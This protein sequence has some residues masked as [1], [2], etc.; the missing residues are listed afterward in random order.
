MHRFVLDASALVKR[1]ATEVGTPLLNHLFHRAGRPRLACP[2]LG[3]AE[4][5]ATLVRKR[6]RGDL[7][8]TVF[9]AA[10]LAFQS[11]VLNAADFLKLSADNALILRSIPLADRHSINANDAVVLLSALDLALSL[12]TAGDDLVLITADQRLLRA[13]R[14]EGLVTFDSETQPQADLDA[15]LGP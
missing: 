8:P 1:Y 12:R 4:V 11:E 14:A 6:N 10:M 7:T 2:M 13:A 15:L 9:T 3:A 5:A